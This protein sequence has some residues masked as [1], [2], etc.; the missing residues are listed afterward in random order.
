MH[1]SPPQYACHLGGGGGA[2]LTVTADDASLMLACSV[3]KQHM[4]V[5]GAQQG[6]HR[7]G[8]DMETVQFMMQVV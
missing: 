5:T 1:A 3:I 8:S 4:T 6:Q 7:A 2:G